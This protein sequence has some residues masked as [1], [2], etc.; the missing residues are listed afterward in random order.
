MHSSKNPSLARRLRID[1]L[2]AQLAPLDRYGLT[3]FGSIIAEGI[4][5]LAGGWREALCGSVREDVA[6]D[7]EAA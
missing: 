6:L 3:G 5:T 7:C 2:K 4:R 1:D